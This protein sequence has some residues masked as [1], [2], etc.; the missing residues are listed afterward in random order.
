MPIEYQVLEDGNL[1]LTVFSG[2]ITADELIEHTRDFVGDTRIQP[3]HRELA[4]FRQARTTDISSRQMDTAVNMELNAE[5]LM[6]ARLALFAPEDIQYGMCRMYLAL[7]D[8][9]PRAEVRIFRDVEQARKW[10]GI[11]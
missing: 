11:P 3:G 8:D 6:D 9:T 1:V 5:R 7:A 4:D 2:H 10:L